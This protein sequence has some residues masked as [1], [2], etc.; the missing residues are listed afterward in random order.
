MSNSCNLIDNACTLHNRHFARSQF[1]LVILSLL[2]KENISP[3]SQN[4]TLKYI[5]HINSNENA[6]KKG[7]AITK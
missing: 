5:M 4:N 3:N 2:E 7:F 6:N 1:S